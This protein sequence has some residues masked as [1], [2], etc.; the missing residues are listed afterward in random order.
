MAWAQNRKNQA[1]YAKFVIKISQQTFGATLSKKEVLFGVP[2]I[3]I[4]VSYVYDYDV[5]TMIVNHIIQL[6]NYLSYS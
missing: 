2:T 4:G 1:Y 3:S 5:C 6:R